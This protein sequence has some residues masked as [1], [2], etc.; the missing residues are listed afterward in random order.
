MKNKMLGLLTVSLLAGPMAA[1]AALIYTFNYDALDEYEAAEISFT[2]SS[3]ATNVGDTLTYLSGGINGCSPTT[4]TLDS[5]NA[6]ATPVFANG[7]C[8]DG[9][10]PAVD[11]LF[12]RPDIMPPLTTGVFVST[13][14]AGRQFEGVGGSNSYRYTSGV[15]TIA[16]LVSVPE[17]GTL[18]LL[19]IGFAALGFAR[20]RNVS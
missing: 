4:L 14:V 8:G 15:L 18:S 16:D 19:G 10:G 1:N 7:S 9:T 17:P 13:G 12:F 2:S 6:F 11:G 20:R 3:F 5:L